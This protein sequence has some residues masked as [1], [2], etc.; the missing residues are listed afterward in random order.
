M[1]KGGLREW[2]EKGYPLE[3]GQALTDLP[4]AADGR[5]L[6]AQHCSTCHGESGKGVPGHF[7][8]LRDDPLLAAPDPWGAIYVTLYGLS[9]RPVAGRQWEARMGGFARYLSDTEAAALVSYARA[10]F[11]LGAGPVAPSDVAKVRRQV[12]SAR[13]SRE[14][15]KAIAP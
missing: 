8:P 12:E 13:A 10:Q 11:V 7:P 14:A 3:K 9:G 15:S 4:Y 5:R 1:L 6:Y 2:R